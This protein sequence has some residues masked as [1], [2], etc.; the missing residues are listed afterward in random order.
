MSPSAAVVDYLLNTAEPLPGK[1]RSA[2]ALPWNPPTWQRGMLDDQTSK[3]NTKDTQSKTVAQ[4]AFPHSCPVDNSV[5]WENEE[6]SGG[7]ASGNTPTESSSVGHV[8]SLGVRAD[9]L[10]YIVHQ[11]TKVL[12]DWQVNLETPKPQHEPSHLQMATT[13]EAHDIQCHENPG[14]KAT[15]NVT[16]V[17]TADHKEGPYQGPTIIDGSIEEHYVPPQTINTPDCVHRGRTVTRQAGPGF[18]IRPLPM[19]QA[20]Q[21]VQYDLTPTRQTGPQVYHGPIPMPRADLDVQYD[22]TPTRQA[23][24][25][26]YIAPLPMSR[27]DQDVQHDQTPMRQPGSD[28]YYGPPPTRVAALYLPPG[29]TPI[30]QAGQDV[31]Y[32]QTPSRQAISG[33]SLYP[34][35]IFTGMILGTSMISDAFNFRASIVSKPAEQEAISQVLYR[36]HPD[37]DPAAIHDMGPFWV[38]SNPHLLCFPAH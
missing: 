4:A 17:C 32:D 12:T 27:A 38:S 35:T 29:P 18:S 3:R 14:L 1:T 8:D 24:L 10:L 19:G 21:G 22:Q 11:P 36:N 30:P 31:Q 37:L 20:D 13:T 33:E 16:P 5:S 26:S 2:S 28:A 9:L 25:G 15:E 34:T 6:V 7:S 23:G